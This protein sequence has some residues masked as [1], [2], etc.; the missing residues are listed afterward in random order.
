MHTQK[1]LT[2]YHPEKLP[3]SNISPRDDDGNLYAEISIEIL[4]NGD[5]NVGI[6]PSWDGDGDKGLLQ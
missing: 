4:A 2:S 5:S 6:L 3:N 1:L